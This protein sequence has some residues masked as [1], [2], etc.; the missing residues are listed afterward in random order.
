MAVQSGIPAAIFVLGAFSAAGVGAAAVQVT[1]WYE[2]SKPASIAAPP[3]RVYEAL[4]G[5]VGSW[6][7][8]ND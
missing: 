8:R 5:A 1:S 3:G 7:D 2:I 4:V 6:W